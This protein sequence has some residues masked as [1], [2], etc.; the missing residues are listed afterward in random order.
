MTDV[1]N[2]LYGQTT[3]L[4]LPSA[5]TMSFAARKLDMMPVELLQLI[6]T[7]TDFASLKALILTS[8]TFYKVFKAAEH[9]ILLKIL[10]NEIRPDVLP[11]A[12]TVYATTGNTPQNY[13]L[14]GKFLPQFED[15]QP[16]PPERLSTSDILS[17]C[18]F[19]KVIRYYTA[20][21]AST[22][23]TNV[24]EQMAHGTSTFLNSG[25]LARIERAFYYFELYC[26]LSSK[27]E[28]NESQWKPKPNSD[29]AP[30]FLQRFAPW[31][32]EQL[33]S[34]NERVYHLL[35]DCK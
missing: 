3:I 21:F 6:L 27:Y 24:A 23:L 8:S 16:L 19:H 7:S 20:D 1:N 28:G 30:Y 5:S 26:N 15:Q 4:T 32:V 14:I 2:K 22:C 12:L 33:A 25:E 18:K 17:I 11:D 35:S 34:V 9:L 10:F 31:E 29:V 13:G